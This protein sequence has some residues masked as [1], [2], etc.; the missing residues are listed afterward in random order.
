MIVDPSTI[1]PNLIVGPFVILLSF[2]AVWLRRLYFEYTERR[3]KEW[4]GRAGWEVSKRSSPFWIGAAGVGGMVIG[5]LMIGF[6]VFGAF[7]HWI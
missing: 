4:Y 3:L 7:Q 2:L 1:V 6:A 5:A